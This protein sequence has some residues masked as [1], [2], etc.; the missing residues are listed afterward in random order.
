M[1]PF[2]AIAAIL[3]LII[4]FYLATPFRKT[5][6]NTSDLSDSRQQQNIALAQKKKQ[7]LEQ[8]HQDGSIDQATLDKLLNE[9]TLS[10]ANDIDEASATSQ[11]SHNATDN[12]KALL[13]STLILIPLLATAIYLKIGNTNA[14]DPIARTPHEQLD[15]QDI[16]TMLANLEQHLA[17]N[18]SDAQGWQILA[19]SHLASGRLNEAAQALKKVLEL[20]GEDA[21]LHAKLAD[22]IAL[23][24]KG[25]IDNEVKGHIDA[26]LRL[27]PMHPQ[28]LWLA[29]LAQMQAGEMAA[30]RGYWD[31]LLPLLDEMPQQK[32]ELTRIIEQSYAQEQSLTTIPA[33]PT[34]TSASS[35][36]TSSLPPE[37]EK[38]V[39]DSTSSI[40]AYISI[41]SAIQSQ[42]NPHDT[43]FVIAKAQQGPP[44]P[45]AVK[46][47][48]VKDLPTTVSLSD[49][50]AML[51]QM[52]LSRFEKISVTAR[53]SKSGD[54]IS[55]AGDLQSDTINTSNTTN[56]T[57]QLLINKVLP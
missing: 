3:T 22:T 16:Q 46:R 7:E 15:Q 27:Q 42:A 30:A 5:K 18:P 2:I 49:A 40:T 24:N 33:E 51:P 4:L 11:S 19:R 14:I 38:A 34:S 10:L 55:K 45:L 8:L 31:T 36:S 35:Q 44:A 43:I 1:T 23:A 41:D 26:A 20:T 54:P 48:Q 37:S 57:L 50:D 32:Q 47:L 12:T 56:E 13:I 25:L 28:A 21:D 29:G 6:S 39:E 9:L 17:E 53:I 52:V